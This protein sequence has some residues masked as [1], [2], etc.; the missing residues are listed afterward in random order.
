ME[1]GEKE[2]I[3]RYADNSDYSWLIENDKHISEK[4]LKSKIENNE[5]YVV[6]IN[7]KLI[8]WLRY[9]LFWDNT[10]FLNMIFLLDGY[11]N[12]GIGHKLMEFW[13]TEMK[14][15]GYKLLMTSSLSNE[16]AQHFY[17]KLNYIDSGELTLK[18][19]PL[20][21]IFTKEI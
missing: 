3:I 5:V 9:N 20:E 10:P 12:K 11:R 21:I 15:K 7:G 6:E 13:E 17:R 14:E 8:G 1:I 16:Q 19:E 4:I 18:N 2:I